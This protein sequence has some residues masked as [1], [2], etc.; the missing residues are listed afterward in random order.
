[1]L[2]KHFSLPAL[3]ALGLFAVTPSAHATFGQPLHGGCYKSA[4]NVCRIHVEPFTVPVD[5]GGGER[6][7]QFRIFANN[8]SG[9]ASFTL[10]E[11]STS[12]QYGYKPVGDF[13]PTLPAEDFTAECGQ[14]YFLN[15]LTRGDT[16]DITG[17]FGNAGVTAEFI[18]PN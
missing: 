18:C 8:M 2:H 12:D 15:I 16:A 17:T 11:F 10:W 7:A 4:P 14:T 3:L 9:G 5:S 1:M 6:V 13:S